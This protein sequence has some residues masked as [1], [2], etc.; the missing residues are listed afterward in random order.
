MEETVEVVELFPESVD[1]RIVDFPVPPMVKEIPIIVSSS[2]NAAHAAPTPMN[3]CAAPVRDVAHATP[4]P[5]IDVPMHNNVGQE[6]IP[7]TLNPVG[8]STV[9][10]P[11]TDEISRKL[12]TTIDALSPLN[13][14]TDLALRME[15][16]VAEVEN[17]SVMALRTNTSLLPDP[18]RRKIFPMPRISEQSTRR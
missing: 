11:M 8:I 4:A 15:T 2:Q 3:E 16:I 10:K 18:K 13:G 17:A 9:Q 1:E 14:L 12:D 7:T 5:E 6:L